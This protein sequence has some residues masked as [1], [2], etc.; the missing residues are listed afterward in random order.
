M[1]EFMRGVTSLAITSDTFKQPVGHY[2]AE[3]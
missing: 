3:F 1:E 2:Q